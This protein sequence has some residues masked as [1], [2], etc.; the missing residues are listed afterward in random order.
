MNKN[1][2]IVAAHADDELL[3]CG[4]TIAR[5]VEEGNHVSV[6]FVADGITSRI[7]ASSDEIPVRNQVARNALAVLGVED[8]YFLGM[9]DNKLDSYPLLDVVQSLEKIIFKISP[10][11]IYTH[12]FGDLNIDHQIVYRAVM[13]ACRP[14]PGI[15]VRKI[16]CFEVMSSTDW[17][18]NTFEV[19]SP[20]VYVDIEKY[21]ELKKNALQL[22]ADEMRKYPHS[23]SLQHIES[24]SRYRGAS[25]G[26]ERAEAFKLVRWIK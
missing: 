14:V 26:L 19:F 18:F 2:L 16:L 6:I 5:H 11:I 21:W 3:G 7:A 20:D 17:S 22:Y 15:S 24:L 13:T 8:I 1:I 10:E 23:R 9:L 12:H 4:G 25:V